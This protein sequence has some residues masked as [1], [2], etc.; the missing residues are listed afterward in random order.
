[1]KIQFS[2]YERTAG[3][4]VL[5]AAAGFC[6]FAFVVAIKQGWFV[7]RHHL[8]TTFTQAEGVHSG[9]L[10]QISGLRAGSVES[11]S[12]SDDNRILVNLS[13]SHDFKKRIKSDSVARVIRPFIIGDKVIEVTVGSKEN[14]EIPEK[15]EIKSEDALDL[16]DMLGGGKLGPYLRQLDSLV[17]NVQVIVEAFSDQKRSRALIRMFDQALPTMMDIRELSQQMTN[18]KNLESSMK[19]LSSLT[20]E[21]NH[22]MPQMAEFAKNLPELGESG[23]KTMVQLAIMTGELKKILPAIAAVAPQLPEASQKSVEA[24][25]E[26]VIVLRAMQKSFLLK[27]AVKDVREEDALK[28]QKT[29]NRMPG[30]ESK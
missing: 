27:G 15:G 5:I 4:F 24:L 22:M 13:I 16:M 18:H 3:L 2:K 30:S 26:A 7:S 8:K 9:T 12:L 21:L 19:N 1:M 10:V 17:K 29:Q 14:P 6:F 11:V 25:K 23:S 28:E 20:S